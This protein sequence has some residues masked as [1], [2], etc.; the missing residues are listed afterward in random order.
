M[1]RMSRTELIEIIYALQQNERTLREEKDVLQKQLEEKVLRLEKAGSIAEAALS[2]NH[3]FEDAENAA[4]QYIDSLKLSDADILAHQKSE[5]MLSEAQA[6]LQQI[7]DECQTM[8]ERTQDAC[9]SIQEQAQDECRS[10]REQAE[11]ECQVMREQVEDECQAMREQAEKGCQAMREQ[12]ENKCQSLYA[13]AE[14]DIRARKDAYV[15]S[16]RNTL[17]KHPE[18]KKNLKQ[19]PAYKWRRVRSSHL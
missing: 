3:I 11:K 16:V 18:L 9:R 13:Q 5:K 10:M 8:Q 6:H 17:D 7:E 1:R 19:D 12:T 4:Q 15:R 2:V 14:A